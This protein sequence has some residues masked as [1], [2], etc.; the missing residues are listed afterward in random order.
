VGP[1]VTRAAPISQP[2]NLPISQPTNLPTYQPTNL[3]ISQ[4]TNLPTYQPTD[5]PIY[6][7]NLPVITF[8]LLTLLTA[9]LLTFSVEF[10]YLRDTFGTRMNTVFKFYFQAWVLLALVA[11]FSVV[12]LAR[13]AG[14]ALRWGGLTV[15]TLLVVAGLFYP[16]F[17]TYTRAERFNTQPTLDGTAYLA[18]QNPADAAA[19]D[20]LR[21]NVPGVAT[22]LE[23]HGGSYTYA[24]RISAQTGLPTLLGWEGHELQWRGNTV[25]QDQRKPI[26][27]R[28]YGSATGPSC[29]GCST[30]GRSTTCWWASRSGAP[31]ASR[32][33]PR[34]VW[35]KSWSWSTM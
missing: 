4:P 34:R 10:V 11:S 14:R 19:V 26:L 21:H 31:T 5:S 9:L 2:P 15:V 16:V 27:E 30:V 25:E 17:A 33:S 28:I 13:F 35:P 6:L 22:V 3:P 7:P 12:Y 32:P 1:A 29:K 23:A 20:W 24:G 8:A 18:R